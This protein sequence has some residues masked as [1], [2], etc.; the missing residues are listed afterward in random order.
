MADF[1]VEIE[2]VVVEERVHFFSP[3]AAEMAG[4]VTIRRALSA[5]AAVGLSLR[6]PLVREI[7]RVDREGEERG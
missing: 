4:E 2:C 7:A 1:R 6:E 3:D 5:L